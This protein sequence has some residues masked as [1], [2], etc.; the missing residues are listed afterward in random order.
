MKAIKIAIAGLI[1]A[2]AVIL[3]VLNQ[4]HGKAPAEPGIVISEQPMDGF[5]SMQEPVTEKKQLAKP[6]NI[7]N[8]PDAVVEEKPI[9]PVQTVE[10]RDDA[11]LFE[12]EALHGT[13]FD[14]AIT[15]PFD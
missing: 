13:P 4:S 9:E 1:M 5:L 7:S 3:L 14:Q 10:E 15:M 6:I 8:T 12:A 2:S 11:M